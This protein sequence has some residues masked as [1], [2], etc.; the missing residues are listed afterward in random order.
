MH[1]GGPRVLAAA[2]L[3]V[4]GLAGCGAAA[5]S[6]GGTASSTGGASASG[7]ASA[8]A[9]TGGA[10]ASGSASAA[11]Q[12]RGAAV[13]APGHGTPEDAADGMIQAEL[14]GNQRLACSYFVPAQQA[15]C[16][17]LLLTLPK[18]HVSVVGA[19]TSGDLALVEIT[20]RMCVSANVCQ[21][22]TDPSIGLPRGSKTFRQAYEDAF[23]STAFSPV[24]CKKLKGK[25]YVNSVVP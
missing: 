12:T 3:V 23:N 20:G 16:R 5:T 17:G 18:G 6:S 7:S 10:S 19:I 14:S 22:S 21:T 15:S 13:V 8:A 9:Q 24:P 2:A 4:V 1:G 25:W 11:A